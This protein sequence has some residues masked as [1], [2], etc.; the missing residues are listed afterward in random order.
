MLLAA[1]NLSV[2]VS[3][4]KQVCGMSRRNPPEICTIPVATSTADPG[5]LTSSPVSSIADGFTSYP[6]ISDMAVTYPLLL[7]FPALFGWQVV[8]V[9]FSE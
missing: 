9:H 8:C 6:Y 3:S 1:Q 4:G 7:G 5:H 2:E